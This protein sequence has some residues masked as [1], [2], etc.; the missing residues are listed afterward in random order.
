MVTLGF[1]PAR[2]QLNKSDTVFFQLRTSLTGNLQRGNVD[3]FALRSKVDFSLAPTRAVVFK[4]QNSGLYQVFYSVKADNDLFS[5]NYLY[6]Q[7]HRRAYPFAI[8]YGS[9]NYRRKIDFRYFTGAGVTVRLWNR[10]LDGLKV[11]VGAVY[12]NTRFAVTSYNDGRYNG[13]QTIA[14]WRAT[15]WLGGWHSLD[16]HLR[17]YY[18]AFWQPAF[19]RASNY[20]WQADVGLDLLVWRGLAFNAFYTYA[21]ENVVVTKVRPNDQMLTFGFS[22]NWRRNYPAR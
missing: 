7:P 20:R 13:S 3:A 12:E 10:Q 16:N 1:G 19:S 15:S 2:A 14:L 17:L 4:S 21:H 5:R 11:S 8:G 22:Y 9:T 6:Y 18:D